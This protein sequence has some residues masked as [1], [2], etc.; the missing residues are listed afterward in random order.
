[1]QP[2]PSPEHPTTMIPHG[3]R[4]DPTNASAL[5]A[6][7]AASS[8]ASLGLRLAQRAFAAC[9]EDATSHGANGR[10]FHAARLRSMARRTL[11]AL[12]ADDRS[13]L[14]RWLSLQFA[15]AFALDSTFAS[16]W[17][18]RVDSRL[19]MSVQTTAA[20]LREQ[21]RVLPGNGAAA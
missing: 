16:R 12:S 3:V 2:F 15:T 18:G 11:S 10:A 5:A 4:S 20:N 9:I 17:L 19:D 7:D 6:A 8:A 14:D 13:K 1:M 21:L